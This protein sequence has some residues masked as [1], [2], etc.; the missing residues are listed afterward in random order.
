VLYAVNTGGAALGCFLTDFL[1]V[2][3]SG[4][5]R[6]QLVAVLFNVVAA[7]ATFLV[8]RNVRLKPDA[9]V[10]VTALPSSPFR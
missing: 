1:L 4:L 9:T 8:A 6:T 2:P 7:V 3:V 5:L 10:K